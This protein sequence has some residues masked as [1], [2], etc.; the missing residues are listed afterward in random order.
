MKYLPNRASYKF[1][2]RPEAASA[3]LESTFKAFHLQQKI[4]E[5]SVVERWEELV[6][7]ELTQVAVPEKITRGRILVIRVADSIWAQ[8]LTLQK[9][10]LLRRL[11]ERP[12]GPAI[13]DIRFVVSGPRDLQ[14]GRGRAGN[15]D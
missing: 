4:K 11:R 12:S 3:L 6:G 8:E 14:R 13:E 7:P 9:P 2:R 10:S 5:Y 15:S 1:A